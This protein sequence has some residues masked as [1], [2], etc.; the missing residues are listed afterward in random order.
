MWSQID[1]CQSNIMNTTICSPLK[2]KW[3]C[4]ICST[5]YAAAP[6]N[7]CYSS[8]RCKDH[9]KSTSCATKRKR[10]N[11]DVP[12]SLQTFLRAAVLQKVSVDS[13][14][15]AEIPTVV[16]CDPE[17]ITAYINELSLYSKSNFWIMG[18]GGK[19]QITGKGER[20]KRK[21][22][23]AKEASNVKDYDKVHKK[24]QKNTYAC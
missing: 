3:T 21:S 22:P 24:R 19:I 5:F 16:C 4:L 11:G 6:K 9:F 12:S 2:L 10:H 8:G 15:K 1:E 14:Y 7:Q 20:Y 18:S 13:L 17:T 23:I